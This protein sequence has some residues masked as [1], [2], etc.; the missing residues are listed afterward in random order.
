MGQL[1]AQTLE[2]VWLHASGVCQDVVVSG[3][4]C[5]LAHRLGNEEEV[6]PASTACI[7]LVSVSILVSITDHHLG[8]SLHLGINH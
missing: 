7:I 5:A 1:V 4:N 2:V 6:I 8:I 3:A